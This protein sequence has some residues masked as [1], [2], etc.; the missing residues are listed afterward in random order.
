M[1]KHYSFLLWQKAIFL[2]VILCLFHSESVFSVSAYPGLIDFRQPDGST[3]KIY[4]RGSEFTKWAETEDGYSLMYDKKGF[5]V[6]AE[7][8]L[9]GDMVPTE[10]RA[11]N[12]NQRMGIIQQRLTNIPKKLQYSK[13]QVQTMQKVMKERMKLDK[14]ETRSIEEGKAP[15]VGTRRFLVILVEFPDLRFSTDKS[16]FEALMNQL[17]YTKYGNQGSVRDFYKENSFGKLDLI[18]D[19]VG[20]YQA[21]HESK[22][23]GEN[24]SDGHDAHPQELAA[25]AVAMAAKDVDYTNYDNDNDGVVEGVHII[26][27]GH[28]EEAGGG[29]DCIWSHMSTTYGYYN[30]KQI[31]HYSCSPELRGSQENKMTYIGVICHE[32]G[33]VLG[34]ADF[35]DTDYQVGGQ[36]DGTSDW[37][38]MGSGNWNKDGACPAHF[39]PYVKIYDFGWGEVTEVNEP[40]STQLHSKRSTDFVRINTQTPNEY[41][42]LEY[43]SQDGFDSYI[44]GHG[45]MIYHASGD[46]RLEAG[47]TIN[48]THPQG[49][50]PVSPLSPTALPTNCDTYGTYWNCMYP[51]KNNITEFTDFTTPAMLSWSELPT[52]KPITNIIENVTEQYATFDV[53]GGGYGSAHGIYIINSDINSISIGWKN[54]NNKT[55]L[56]ACNTTPEFGTLQNKN[57]QVG[58]K[59]DNGGTVVY[60]GTETEFVHTGLQE[61][62]IYYYK[63]FSNIG[64]EYQWLAG[65]EIKAMTNTGIIRKFPFIEDF[66]NGEPADWQQEYALAKY[67]WKNRP[68][69][70][71]NV[72]IFSNGTGFEYIDMECDTEASISTSF[73]KHYITKLISPII[74]FS[75]KECAIAKFKCYNKNHTLR[76]YYRNSTKAKWSLLQTFLPSS[77]YTIWSDIQIE[78]PNLSSEYQIAFEGD[79]DLGTNDAVSNQE[80]IGIDDFQIE[81]DFP[82]LITTQNLQLKYAAQTTALNVPINIIQGNEKIIEK[83]IAYHS[84]DQYTD[85]IWQKVQSN[86]LVGEVALRNL[87]KQ[88]SIYYRIYAVTEKGTYYGET[89]YAEIIQFAQGEGTASSPF[90]INTAEEWEKIA[91][92]YGANYD[93]NNIYFL[94]TDTMTLSPMLPNDGSTGF[95]GHIDGNHH[96]IKLGKRYFN[97]SY[98][99]S[100]YLLSILGEKGSIKNIRMVKP[101]TG[102]IGTITSTNHGKITNCEVENSSISHT[103][104]GVIGNCYSTFNCTVTESGYI[105][106]ICNKNYGLIELCNFTGNIFCTNNDNIGGICGINYEATLMNGVTIRGT[107]RN[108]MADGLFSSLDKES[109]FNQMGGIAGSNYG[110]IE[111]CINHADIISKTVNTKAPDLGGG[112]SGYCGQRCIIQN[113]YNIG[114]IQ[115][116]IQEAYTGGIVGEARGSIANCFSTGDTPGNNGAIIGINTDGYISNCYHMK[117]ED[118]FSTLITSDFLAS[119]QFVDQLNKETQTPCWQYVA[120]KGLPVLTTETNK[121]SLYALPCSDFS[122]NHF[123]IQGIALKDKTIG[124]GMEWKKETDSGWMRIASDT[125]SII[126]IK[127]ENCLPGTSYTYRVYAIS[128]DGSQFYGNEQ[129]AATLFDYAGSNIDPILIHDKDELWTLNQ[130]VQQGYAFASQSVKLINDIDLQGKL[131]TPLNET[132][133][134]DFNGNQKTI[135]NMRIVVN[136]LF[137][138]FIGVTFRNASIHDLSFRNAYVESTANTPKPFYN[139]GVGGIVGGNIGDGI[140]IYNCSFHGTVKGGYLVGGIIGDGGTSKEIRNCFAIADL[141]TD[142]IGEKDTKAIGGIAGMGNIT[143]SY[144]IGSISSS[145]SP[146]SCGGI[147]GYNQYA[148]SNNSYY[149]MTNTPEMPLNDL[150]ISKT[151]EEMK[152]TEIIDLLNGPDSEEKKWVRDNQDNPINSGYPLFSWQALS[153]TT[154]LPIEKEGVQV[155]LNGLYRPSIQEATIVSKGF[156][157]MALQDTITK[158]ITLKPEDE[159]KITLST[160]SANKQYYY[161]AFVEFNPETRSLSKEY[162]E[163]VTFI[164]PAIEPELAVYAITADKR[165]ASFKGKYT[166]GSETIAGIG[167]EYNITGDEETMLAMTDNGKPDVE[168]TDLVPG[169]FYEVRTVAFTNE[170]RKYRSVPFVWKQPITKGDANGSDLI[171]VADIVNTVDYIIDSTPATF[172]F[173]N[174]DINEDGQV[175]IADV[176]LIVNMIFDIQKS[177]HTRAGD[178]DITENILFREG[179]LL[180]IISATPLAGFDFAYTGDLGRLPELKDFT[181]THYQK[182]GKQ[183]ILAYTTKQVL[184]KGIHSLFSISDNSSISDM[185]FVAPDGSKIAFVEKVYTSIPEEESGMKIIV[186]HDRISIEGGET[187]Q[188]ISIYSSN[189]MKVL[190]KSNANEIEINALP[191]GVYILKIGTENGYKTQKFSKD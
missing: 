45:L 188:L 14:A 130:L 28:G 36:Y 119:S 164:Q 184:S 71:E 16:E 137:A 51:G 127:I 66:E 142:L 129:K 123:T 96:P 34:C 178:I 182:K 107:I 25:E 181:I 148:G 93:F 140:S 109:Y 61:H 156:E 53:C 52:N 39:N 32:L 77:N 102:S 111:Q 48:T 42:L 103:N 17:N 120:G 38:V 50:Y 67:S 55:V 141:S 69:D 2:L 59:I 134:G 64:E 85:I 189:G 138:G 24:W 174:A 180:K 162:G 9:N 79:R 108:C 100:G 56:V 186:S 175:D 135:Y 126:N 58:D 124:Y 191:Q 47:N 44:P 84:A 80:F 168:V 139:T 165:K 155:V 132:F 99:E 4:I 158:I 173:A 176:V 8:N 6:F 149:S 10:M 116:S 152:D 78:L 143:D 153:C 41:Y 161:R 26:F 18:S 31:S 167:F 104:Y 187:P 21:K 95:N 89:Q 115:S 110:N 151:I 15:I 29:A 90:L 101:D 19:V 170:S 169:A 33:H 12:T 40:Y 159:F 63:L 185:H 128:E 88:Q 105:G 163:W 70:P 72:H 171:N 145:T 172:F 160:L 76:V 37:D 131:W 5:L 23:Y 75:N 74:D 136:D 113:C 92:N 147:A 82:I 20:V 13:Q 86:N 3:V 11:A 27:A 146:Y 43:R 30:R 177:T 49:F 154:T 125:S 190:E 62:H 46:L 54:P 94:I 157:W 133:Q 121:Y 144:F 106:G 73:G 68:A 87:P 122:K 98:T 150:G 166:P 7:R 179:N 91:M 114:N 81:V 57:Y 65:T 183:R 60:T 117:G 118:K 22:F 35:Y 97:A 83:G 1:E 112:I